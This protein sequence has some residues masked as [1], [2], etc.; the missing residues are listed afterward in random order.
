MP[1]MPA[2]SATSSLIVMG[3]AAGAVCSAL[4]RILPVPVSRALT[5][6]AA[7]PAGSDQVVAGPAMRV[8][9]TALVPSMPPRG[10]S[11]DT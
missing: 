4:Q 9:V 3:E 1:S 5:R 6:P 7:G 11:G 8:P 2:W 10:P